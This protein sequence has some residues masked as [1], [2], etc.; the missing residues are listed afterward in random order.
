MRAQ[1]E[2]IGPLECIRHGNPKAS[3]AVVLFHGYGADAGD[4][5]PFG[6]MLSVGDDVQWIFPNGTIEVPIGPGFY[7]RAWFKI[8]M[9][10]LERAM[11]LGRHRDMTDMRPEGLTEARTATEECI[12]ALGIPMDRIVLGGFSQGAMLATEVALHA[13]ENPAGLLA[14]SGTMLDSEQWQARAKSRPALPYYMSHGRQDPLLNP[15][16][17]LRWHEYLQQVGWP[18]EFTLFGGG[19]EIPGV[20]QEKMASFIRSAFHA[21]NH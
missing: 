12:K 18:G 19:H 3:H 4:L 21:K 14:L 11:M 20:V 1:M 10:A 9:A 7:G 8:D 2:K 6:S 17:A 13:K 16:D 5:A 15:E